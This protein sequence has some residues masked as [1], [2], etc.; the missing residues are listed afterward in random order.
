MGHHG[1]RDDDGFGGG[2]QVS[3]A[4]SDT[5]ELEFDSVSAGGTHTCAI[6]TA[7]ALT[8]WGTLV[9]AEGSLVDAEDYVSGTR[10]SR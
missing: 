1:G 9:D 5:E 6:D 10:T 4:P 7:G 2:G 3:D 8:C